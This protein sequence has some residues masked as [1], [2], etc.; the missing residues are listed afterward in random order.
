M[1]WT[2][3]I[4]VVLG[5]GLGWMVVSFLFGRR[6]PPPPAAPPASEPGADEIAIPDPMLG[7]PPAQHDAA[8][9]ERRS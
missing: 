5:L 1:N 9:G 4:V 6:A 3:A 8:D 2:V 7:D